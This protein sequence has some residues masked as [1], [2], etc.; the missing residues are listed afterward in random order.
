MR[1]SK[2]TQLASP[3]PYLVLHSE[4]LALPISATASTTASYE[5]SYVSHDF[6]HCPLVKWPKEGLTLTK[7]NPWD[8]NSLRLTKP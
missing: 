4:A 5:L 3:L 6:H 1:T 7:L 8:S 2:I